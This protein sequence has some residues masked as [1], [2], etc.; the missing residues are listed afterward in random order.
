MVA[1]L[2]VL[3]ISRKNTGTSQIPAEAQFYPFSESE[4]IGFKKR[5]NCNLIR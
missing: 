3:S 1:K 5:R 4:E 2:T